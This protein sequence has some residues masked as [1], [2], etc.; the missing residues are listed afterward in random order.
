LR[1]VRVVEHPETGPE[2]HLLMAV[3]QFRERRFALSPVEGFISRRGEYGDQLDIRS[4][5]HDSIT[6]T[7]RSSFHK[8]LGGTGDS[9]GGFFQVTLSR[10][11][12]QDEIP[13]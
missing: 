4:C 3:N 1:L 8:R 2:H 12:A 7:E 6:L 10:L 11:D 13:F 9:L 5:L